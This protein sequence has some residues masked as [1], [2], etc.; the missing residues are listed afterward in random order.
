VLLNDTIDK[1]GLEETEKELLRATMEREMVELLDI[2]NDN[3]EF[4][5][6]YS[7][8]S[9]KIHS[10]HLF[11]SGYQEAKKQSGWSKDKIDLME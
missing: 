7:E 4:K 3:F 5:N 1:K 9:V 11:I 2:Y 6:I 8:L 10:P